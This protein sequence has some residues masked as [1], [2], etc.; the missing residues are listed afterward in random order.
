MHASD[1]LD[2]V[3]FAASLPRQRRRLKRDDTK[4]RRLRHELADLHIDQFRSRRNSFASPLD[5]VTN[6]G[7]G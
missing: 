7:H 6:A 5:G 4:R 2:L 3:R 1:T